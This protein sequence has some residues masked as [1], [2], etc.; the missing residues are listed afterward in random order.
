MTMSSC[1]RS[2]AT[3]PLL[4]SLVAQ[5]AWQLQPVAPPS[6]RTNHVGAYDISRQRVVVHGGSFGNSVR[7]DTLEFNGTAWSVVSPSGG[8]GPRWA[9]GMAYDPT[10]QSMILF[11]GAA[12]VG[13][14]ALAGTWRWNGIA[15]TQLATAVSPP[16]RLAQA[17]TTD[18]VGGRIVMHGGRDS[19]GVHLA[20]TWVFDGTNWSQLAAGGPPARC[21][22][23]LATD[24]GTGDVLLFGG[25][26]GSNFGDTWRLSGN[27]WTQMTPS[28]APSARWGQRM[29][30]SPQLGGIVL[31]G[32][33]AQ[34]FPSAETWLWRGTTWIP[35]LGNGPARLNAIMYEDWQSGLVGMFGGSDQ[36]LA[37]VDETWVLTGSSPA[38]WSPFGSGCAGPAGAIALTVAGLPTLGNAT[39]LTAAPTPLLSVFAFGLSSQP[40]GGISL[41]SIGAPGCWLYIGLDALQSVAPVGQQSQAS[42]SIPL[43]PTLIGSSVF[44]QAA[45]L[46]VAANAL[47][48]VTS[49]AL[50]GTIGW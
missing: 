30:Y 12:T 42:L 41:A 9:A 22:H 38:N 32:G 15:W 16:A 3:L 1:L 35:L 39:V 7:T 34:V 49:N 4:G 50:A 21:C 46:D 43:Q 2:V 40:P 33:L 37:N 17:M 14:S 10:S 27:Q 6:A 18:L 23:S 44:V 20:D 45:S 5:V 47:G 25:W 36:S 26:N 28:F 19:A 31:H 13:G 11:G 29:A 24:V 8:P 48:L